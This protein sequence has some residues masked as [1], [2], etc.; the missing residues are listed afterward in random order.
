KLNLAVL[1]RWN[2]SQKKFRI[3]WTSLDAQASPLMVQG[4]NLD[5]NCDWINNRI[6]NLTG[7]W[8]AKSLSYEPYTVDNIVSALSG[9]HRQIQFHNV[10]A[11]GYHGQLRAE[12]LL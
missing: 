6:E 11:D 12:I 3:D 9:D 5:L 8:T 4:L 10:S 1:S 2:D 7:Q